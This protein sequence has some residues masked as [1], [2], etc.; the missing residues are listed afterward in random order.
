[1]GERIALRQLRYFAAVADA[2]SFRAAAERLHVSQPPLSRQVAQLERV[3]G[4]RL[5]ARGT[6]G[7]SLTPEGHAA[8]ERIRDILARVDALAGF[9]AVAGSARAPVRIGITA[10][11][12]VAQRAGLEAAW[13]QAAPGT[14]L[15]VAIAFSRDILPALKEGR[16]DFALVGLPG[17]LE[18]L[19]SRPVHATPLVAAL[20]SGHRLARRKRV[21]LL[22]V[23]D[24]PLFWIPR[25]HHPG[26]HD[27]CQRYFRRIGYRPQ[28]IVVEPGLIQ[29]L[30]RIAAGEGWATPN[31]A[32]RATR[33]RGVAYRPLV[34]GEDLAVKVV[35]A[36]RTAD[37]GERYERFAAIAA[38]RLGRPAP[39]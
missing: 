38:K 10:A 6:T 3:L 20:P 4:V 19:Q 1:M 8:L 31:A 18:G 14:R 37:A 30:E 33:V 5:L 17:D 15:E 27:L 26:Y 7:A 23:T 21:S 12:T 36:W 16:L 32:S 29:T 24:L 22:E 9:A 13:R 11:L 35:A 2:G 28:T 25:S 39:G 34:E